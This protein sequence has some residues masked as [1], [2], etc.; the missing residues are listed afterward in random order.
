M[1]L[2][3]A[4]WQRRRLLQK[5]QKLNNSLF[6]RVDSQSTIVAARGRLLPLPLPPPFPV[7]T[8]AVRRSRT[9]L[10]SQ[11]MRNSVKKLLMSWLRVLSLR[12]RLLSFDLSLKHALL[13]KMAFLSARTVTRREKMTLL[14]TSN[15]SEGRCLRHA[16]AALKR[17]PRDTMRTRW[18]WTSASCLS[19]IPTQ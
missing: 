2:S 19:A 4:S 9:Q 7:L 15:L 12:Q 5:R 11:C 18:T 8:A 10:A 13:V 14:M 6:L 16:L 3:A 1:P 17:L